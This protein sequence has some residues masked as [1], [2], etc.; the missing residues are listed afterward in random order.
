MMCDGSHGSCTCGGWK[1]PVGRI[2]IGLLFVVA[3]WG[4][5]TNFAGTE[6]YVGTVFPMAALFTVLAI[7][8]ELGGGL[9]LVTGFHARLASWMLIV[10]TALATLG[11]HTDFSQPMQQIMF[12]KNVA[13]IGGLLYV[14]AMGAGKWS[15]SKWDTKICMGG[16]MCPDCKV[17]SPEA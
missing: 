9:M 12:L 16:K 13:I 14:S 7:I 3:G 11:Y 8:F 2:L 4:K 6:Q 10:F 5:L 1:A 17:A 15:L